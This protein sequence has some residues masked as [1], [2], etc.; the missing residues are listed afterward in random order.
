[1]TPGVDFQDSA[2]ASLPSTIIG[3]YVL[4]PLS[5]L[6]LVQGTT[7]S[8]TCHTSCHCLH[9]RIA[10]LAFQTSS[11]LALY[12]VSIYLFAVMPFL[13]LKKFKYIH[14]NQLCATIAD[15]SHNRSP[16]ELVSVQ[17]QDIRQPTLHFLHTCRSANHYQED[18]DFFIEVD[19]D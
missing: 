4:I 10:T 18:E 17:Q 1:V 14:I 11:L 12:G 2:Q 13:V 19:D 9:S 6:N 16:I 7:I 8:A 5:L 3:L 15:N